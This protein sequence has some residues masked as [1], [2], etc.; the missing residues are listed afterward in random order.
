MLASLY[1]QPHQH[2]ARSSPSATRS[3][4]LTP[5]QPPLPPALL[6]WRVCPKTVM[7]L[8]SPRILVRKC[9]LRKRQ[10][11]QHRGPGQTR[12]SVATSIVVHFQSIIRGTTRSGSPGD[13]T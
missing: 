13:L 6:S 9:S 2:L 3:A 5:S 8:G 4:P 12:D 11:Q 1:T 7:S 10:R